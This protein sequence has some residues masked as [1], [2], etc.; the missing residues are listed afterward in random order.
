[1]QLSKLSTMEWDVVYGDVPLEVNYDDWQM[2][3][4]VSF[5]NGV[6]MSYAGAPRIDSTRSD[7][8][9][10]PEFEKDT[11]AKPDGVTYVHDEAVAQRAL[12]LS[13]SILMFGFA[14]V[15][16]PTIEAI[17]LRPGIHL[18]FAAS[19]DGVYTLVVEQDEG[20]VVI[21]PGMNDLKSEE[22][23]KWIGER[24]SDKPIS[25]V[26]VSHSHNDHAA[27]IRPYIAAGATVVV[28][29]AAVD[30]YKDQASR[31]ASRILPDALDQDPKPM[32]IVGVPAD[33]PYRIEDTTRAVVIYPL[34]MGHVPDMVFAYVEG[35]DVLY[36]GDL[37]IGGLARDIRAGKKRP[38]PGILPFHAAVSLN[39][40]IKQYGLEDVA[41]LVSTHD[42]QPLAY[43]DLLTYLSDE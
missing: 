26:S 12:R 31:P 11:F 7:I 35:D 34:V 5:P 15:G 2:V 3:D 28:H 40:G 6:R 16:R 21:E 42:R 14:G 1:G 32:K 20:I 25:H 38:A 4:G 10:N 24:Y 23:I 41:A 36:S 18:V 30:F 33:E 8:R 39:E 29:A 9:V 22:I 43:S 13:Q 27:G 17:E 37:Y 19:I